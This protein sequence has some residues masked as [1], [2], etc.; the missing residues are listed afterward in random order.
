MINNYYF[1]IYNITKDNNTIPILIVSDKFAFLLSPKLSDSRLQYKI[2]NTSYS[3]LSNNCYVD[4]EN[5]LLYNIDELE[6]EIGKLSLEDR[7]NIMSLITNKNKTINNDA[8]VS[9]IVNIGDNVKIVNRE[10]VWNNLEGIVLDIIDE[11]VAV[12]INFPTTNGVKQIEQIFNIK[13]IE[14]I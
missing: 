1:K 5:I 6:D 9:S 2:K 13:E 14:I 10:D 7:L 3:N 12:S 4:L 11:E 8:E